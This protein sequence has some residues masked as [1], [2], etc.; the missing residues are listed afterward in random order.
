M[1]KVGVVLAGG[2]E[3]SMQSIPKLSFFTIVGI[4]CDNNAE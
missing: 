4:K 3:Q 2:D 1:G